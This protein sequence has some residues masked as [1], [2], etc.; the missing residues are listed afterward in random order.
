MGFLPAMV[1]W[2]LGERSPPE[3]RYGQ[4]G[5]GPL[6]PVS[7][8]GHRSSSSGDHRNGQ[9]QFRDQVRFHMPANRVALLTPVMM[10]SLGDAIVVLLS[11][12]LAGE[13]HLND[14]G[15]TEYHDIQGRYRVPRSKR[16]HRITRIGTD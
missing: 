7:P 16:K 5:Q 6:T 8:G 1:R 3:C 11:D 14:P 10:F 4:P 13:V 2:S 9:H 15:F 12:P